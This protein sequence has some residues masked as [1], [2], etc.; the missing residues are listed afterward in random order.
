MVKFSKRVKI[1]AKYLSLLLKQSSN[2]EIQLEFNLI[3]VEV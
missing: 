3:I 2:V 1:A